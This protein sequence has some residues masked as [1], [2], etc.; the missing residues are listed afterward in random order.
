[1][2]SKKT[3]T[4]NHLLNTTI[5]LPVWHEGTSVGTTFQ[6]THSVKTC[7]L[8][9][10]A[11]LVLPLLASAVSAEEESYTRFYENF[12][13]TDVDT[14]KWAVQEN[15]NLSGYPAWGGSIRVN[16]SCV[17]LSSD[18]SV[19]PWISTVTNPFPAS[20]GFVVTW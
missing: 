18:G 14:Q 12:E 6:L 5:S 15:T 19:F 13:G 11:V 9:V 1:M 10:I 2:L 8:L 3:L 7:T 4:K 17:W 20:G 16:D